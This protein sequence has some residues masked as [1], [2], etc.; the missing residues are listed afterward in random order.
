MDGADKRLIDIKRNA[1]ISMT[2][3]TPDDAIRR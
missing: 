1:A 3:G 2:V